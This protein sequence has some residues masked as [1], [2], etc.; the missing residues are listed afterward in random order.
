MLLLLALIAAACS[1]SPQGSQQSTTTT[2]PA[3]SK[4][5]ST[6]TQAPSLA[7]HG[8]LAFDCKSNA[9]ELLDPS[10]GHVLSSQSIP[11]TF[12]TSAGVVQAP[13]DELDICGSQA[14]VEGGSLGLH[15]RQQFNETFSLVAVATSN[16]LSDGS[17]HV[18]YVEIATGTFTDVTQLTLPKGFGSSPP[19]DSSPVFGVNGDFY[20][21]RTEESGSN[22]SCSVEQY[23]PVTKTLTN[24]GSFAC[25]NAALTVENG[26]VAISTV[27]ATVLVDPSGNLAAFGSQN[28]VGLAPVTGHLVGNNPPPDTATFGNSD[29][30][31][32]GW[33]VDRAVLAQ[34]S[35]SNQYQLVPVSS[36][37]NGPVT[38]Q[39]LLP[40][41]SPASTDPVISPDGKTL[42]FLSA[43]GSGTTLF[44]APMV[45]N[46]TPTQIRSSLF[47][48]LLIWQ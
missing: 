20:F 43:S 13:A 6:T 7:A 3:V 35:P 41:D 27:Q 34:Q 1:T 37:T 42:A 30:A 11:F 44:T 26:V 38:T 17:V 45:S 4:A 24:L 29:T 39:S 8:L 5:T 18:G 33:A 9:L 15:I 48:N 16:P 23:A 22:Q 2:A 10:N 32:Y 47:V 19:S 12:N 40:Q 28:G 36:S 31:I 46:A 21:I 25:T 14:N